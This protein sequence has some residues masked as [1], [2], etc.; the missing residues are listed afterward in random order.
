MT[1]NL[2]T[3]QSL[4]QTQPV[5]ASYGLAITVTLRSPVRFPPKLSLEIYHNI[6]LKPNFFTFPLFSLFHPQQSK[7]YPP[8]SDQMNEMSANISIMSW[9]TSLFSLTCFFHTRYNL[10][11]KQSSY[12][13]QVQPRLTALE[14]DTKLSK[15]IGPIFETTKTYGFTLKLHC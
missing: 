2:S 7:C 5:I 15:P 9:R 1:T 13:D 8:G 12:H 11:S 6:D 14:T 4:A 10:M 3:C